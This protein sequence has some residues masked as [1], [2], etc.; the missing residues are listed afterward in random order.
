MRPP[1]SPHSYV[2]ALRTRIPDFCHSAVT[3]P[4]LELKKLHKGVRNEITNLVY[5]RAPGR[6]SPPLPNAAYASLEVGARAIAVPCAYAAQPVGLRRHS[7][8]SRPARW[9]VARCP[10]PRPRMPAGNRS[11]R[12]RSAGGC[13]FLGRS[14]Q[15]GRLRP[16]RPTLLE[17]E[18]RRILYNACSRRSSQ[19]Q[20]TTV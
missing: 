5:L 6:R 20:T 17:P 8:R 18:V 9:Q 12:H 16:A 10:G 2:T 7:Y 11:D 13:P 14:P 19:P 15:P 4:G 3:E 1:R